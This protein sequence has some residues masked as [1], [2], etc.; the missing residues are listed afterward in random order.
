MILIRPSFCIEA[1]NGAD[2]LLMEKAGR[3]CYKSENVGIDGAAFSR[4]KN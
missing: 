4:S 3:T 1:I 2:L